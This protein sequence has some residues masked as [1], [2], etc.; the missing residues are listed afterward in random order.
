MDNLKINSLTVS[1]RIGVYEWEQRINQ[2]LIINITIPYD[3]SAC[4]DNIEN[5]IDYDALCQ[6]ITEFVESKSFKLIETVANEI[7][8]I[9]KQ[10][11]NVKQLTVSVSKP[12]AIKNAGPIEVIVNR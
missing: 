3:F 4:E 2:N 1:T 8:E 6:L 7:A 11:F 5:T 10:Q 9:I 12:H